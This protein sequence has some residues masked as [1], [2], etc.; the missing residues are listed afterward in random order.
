MESDGRWG[1]LLDG[2]HPPRRVCL[3]VTRACGEGHTRREP[4]LTPKKKINYLKYP[5]LGET[6]FFTKPV[7]PQFFVRFR[8]RK[9][10]LL[11]FLRLIASILAL[12]TIALRRNS[13]CWSSGMNSFCWTSKDIYG[14]LRTHLDISGHPSRR[15][16]NYYYSTLHETSQLTV[17]YGR[18]TY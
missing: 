12:C 18:T 11:R 17:K 8:R 6:F 2:S 4:R 13:V 7:C 10:T 15:S 5:T 1:G 9:L 16:H 3:N 14:H